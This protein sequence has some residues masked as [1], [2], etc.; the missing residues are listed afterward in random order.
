MV[1]KF[2]AIGSNALLKPVRFEVDTQFIGNN[3]IDDRTTYMDREGINMRE[4]TAYTTIKNNLNVDG[5]N[6]Q[7]TAPMRG[8]WAKVRTFFGAG[9]KQKINETTVSI[10]MGQRNVSN[11]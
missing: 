7:D 10:R 11:P 2:V 3:G 6:D 1:K 5:A 8:L 9:E 4:N